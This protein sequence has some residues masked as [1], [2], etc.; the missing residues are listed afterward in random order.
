MMLLK[1]KD[2]SLVC[3][4]TR[5]YAKIIL[6][7][8]GVNIPPKKNRIRN[9]L[10]NNMEK[11]NVSSLEKIFLNKLFISS[12]TFGILNCLTKCILIE[13]NQ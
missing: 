11:T 4:P 8:N 13:I 9:A 12:S 7:K 1:P 10:S 2:S 5:R 3:I 6:I